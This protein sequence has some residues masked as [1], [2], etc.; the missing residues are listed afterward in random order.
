VKRALFVLAFCASSAALAQDSEPQTPA[1]ASEPAPTSDQRDVNQLA[2][3]VRELQRQLDES[4]EARLK[5]RAQFESELEK[6]RAQTKVPAEAKAELRARIDAADREIAKLRAANEECGKALSDARKPPARPRAAAVAEPTAPIDATAAPERAS[7]DV[8]ATAPVEAPSSQPSEHPP[9]RRGTT[10]A[11]G[12]LVAV[13]VENMDE[14]NVQIAV[15]SDGTITLPL[16][17]RVQAAGR[18]DR[19]LA[20]DLEHRLTQYLVKPKAEVTVR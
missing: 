10:I 6:A 14:M 17:G 18:T 9:P 15:A 11:P 16:L 5:D 8:P 3:R 4:L 12:S 1:A 19:E 7:I 13:H 20:D 2:T